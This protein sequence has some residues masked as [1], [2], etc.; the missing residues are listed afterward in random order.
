MR[1]RPPAEISV[2]DVIEASIGPVNIVGCLAGEHLCD[3]AGNCEARNI[4]RL[5]N[6]K[7]VDS[8]RDVTLADINAMPESTE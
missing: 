7:L 3:R 5:A 4:W 2:L 8:F 6:Q 1:S